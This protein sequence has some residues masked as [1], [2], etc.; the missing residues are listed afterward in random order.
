MLES[1][2][3][4]IE[5]A[6][7]AVIEGHIDS[8]LVMCDK[9]RTEYDRGLLCADE[10]AARMIEINLVLWKAGMRWKELRKQEA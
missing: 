4:D 9:T 10:L 3:N 6:S 1:I 8:I 5:G 7:M 2:G